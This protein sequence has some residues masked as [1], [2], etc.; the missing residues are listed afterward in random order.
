MAMVNVITVAA[1]RR[2]Y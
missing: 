1:Y 2:I